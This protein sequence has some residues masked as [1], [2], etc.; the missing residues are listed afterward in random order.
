MTASSADA[1]PRDGTPVLD[2]PV[3]L[4]DS[5]P[6][7][8]A[9]LARA[10]L[11]SVGKPGAGAGLP[12]RQVVMTDVAQDLAR[13]AAYD[14]VCGFTL[15]DAVPATWLH[16]LTFPLQLE[17]MAARDFPFPAVG[18]VHI[19]NQ[20]HQHRPVLV[21]EKLTVAVHAEGLRAHR[22]GVALDIVGQVSVGDEVVWDGQSTYLVRGARLPEDSGSQSAGSRDP[23]AETSTQGRPTPIALPELDDLPATRAW[24]RL[25]AGLGREYAGVSGDLNPIHLNPWAA[26]ALGF[27]RTIAHG[28]WSHA[29]ALAALEPRLPEG[30]RARVEF[31]K[32]VLLPSTV[33]FGARTVE[34]QWQFAVTGKDGQRV[35]LLG[36]V[37]PA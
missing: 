7:T 30:Y 22:A 9:L 35:H 34:D 27:P 10:V 13:L 1:S 26:K 17:L 5:L 25:P 21:S 29:A 28:M 32:P 36:A 14:R 12:T 4:H 24:W 31:L 23:A 6:S 16:V 37:A 3:Q 11:G 15:R 18:M 33:R 2:R 20:M 19:S 8:G